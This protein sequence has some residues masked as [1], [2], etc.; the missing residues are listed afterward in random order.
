MSYRRLRTNA[1]YPYCLTFYRWLS[2]VSHPCLRASCDE[3]ITCFTVPGIADTP[4]FVMFYQRLY[5]RVIS[6]LSCFSC[7]QAGCGF[8]FCPH[9]SSTVVLCTISYEDC[10]ANNASFSVSMEVFG[11][12]KECTPMHPEVSHDLAVCRSCCY[13]S[14]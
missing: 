12:A 4:G 10:S 14:F 2:N 6:S 8:R 11:I 7:S 3:P 9:V 13:C 1:S 5:Q